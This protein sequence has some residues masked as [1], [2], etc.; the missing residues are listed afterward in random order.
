M[1]EYS[2]MFFNNKIFKFHNILQPGKLKIYLK[3][4]FKIYF[5]DFDTWLLTYIVTVKLNNPFEQ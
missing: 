4:K 3:K 2:N 5:K 1:H